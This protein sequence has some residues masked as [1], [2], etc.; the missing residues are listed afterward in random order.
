MIEPS[1]GIGRIFYCILEH[2][3][4]QRDNDEKRTV[5]AFKPIVAPDKATVFPLMKASLVA[6]C[7]CLLLCSTYQ[8]CPPRELLCV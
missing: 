7:S 5:F 4:Y 1:F 6:N 2:C 3:Y 8:P